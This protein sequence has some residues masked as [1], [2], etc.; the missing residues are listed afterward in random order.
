MASTPTFDKA[1]IK[2]L[3][4]L[5]D[6]STR[7]GIVSHSR[8]DGDASGC[9]VATLRYLDAVYPGEKDCRILLENA[10]PDSIDF[11]FGAKEQSRTL[12]YEESPEDVRSFVSGCDLLIYL[13][14]NGLNR[15]GSMEEA[16]GGCRAH[17]VLIDHHLNPRR[18]LFDVTFSVTEISSASELLYYILTRLAT[19]GGF[20]LPEACLEPLMTGITTDTNNF[21]NSVHSSTLAAVAQLLEAGVDRN[22]ILYKIY[23]RFPERR[24]R[25]MGKL[26]YDNLT[27]L[28]NGVAYM[29]LDG[30]TTARYGIKQGETEGFVNIPLTIDRVRMSIFMRQDG[31]TIRVSIRSEHGISANRLAS[32]HFNGGGHEQAAGGRLD[33]GVDIPDIES[34]PAYIAAA[35]ANMTEYE[36]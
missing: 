17:K 29:I 2:T 11:L 7:I 1:D 28:E 6:S 25:L 4:G 13:D 26:L 19:D 3:A 22:A 23:N 18:E 27:I 31:G 12:L 14:L 10:V 24:V 34:L 32:L 33:L 9:C 36:V 20:Q 30:E 15:T 8:P 35:T 16:F 5:L 21:D